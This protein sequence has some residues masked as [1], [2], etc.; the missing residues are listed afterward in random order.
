M[1]S[2]VTT[3]QAIIADYK[4]EPDDKATKDEELYKLYLRLKEKYGE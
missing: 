4:K 1:A 2:V 3:S